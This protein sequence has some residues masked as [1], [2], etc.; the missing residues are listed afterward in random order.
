MR[1]ATKFYLSVIIVCCVLCISTGQTLLQHFARDQFELDVILEDSASGAKYYVH[2]TEVP[3]GKKSTLF[4]SNSQIK[5]IDAIYDTSLTTCSV[6]YEQ[7]DYFLIRSI[8]THAGSSTGWKSEG[9]SATISSVESSGLSL[10]TTMCAAV[11]SC[12]FIELDVLRI[13]CEQNKVEYIYFTGES[14][15]NRYNRYTSLEDIPDK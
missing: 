5:I 12:R 7:M 6:L 11:S 15:R 3:S 14:G 1:D 4:G 13:E 9:R 10:D 2:F 8:F